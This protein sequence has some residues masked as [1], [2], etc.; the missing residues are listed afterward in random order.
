MNTRTTQLWCA[1]SGIVFLVLMGV[2]MVVLAQFV[3]PPRAD[4]TTAEVV[5]L[6]SENPDRLRAGLVTIMLAAI[7]TAP[8]TAAISVQLKRIEGHFSPMTYTQLACGAANVLVITFPVMAMIAASF[9]IDRD[10][11][12]TQALNDLGWIPFIMVFPPVMMQCLAIAGAIF[13]APEQ[14]VLPRWLA[15]FQVWCAVVLFP[16]LLLPF[17]KTGAFAWHGI[18]EFWLAAV[19]FFGWFVVTTI[20]LIGAVRRQELRRVEAPA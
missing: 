13:N 5:K 10:P 19:V 4:D 3:P 11:E 2:G 20:V 7:F 6:Y 15:Y 12:I 17:F 18:F 1:Y 16:A 9:R 14:R 8:W